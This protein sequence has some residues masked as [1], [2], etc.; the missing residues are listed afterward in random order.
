[1]KMRLTNLKNL[2]LGICA[3]ALVAS[4]SISTSIDT[5]VQAD[6][7]RVAALKEEAKVPTKI[8]NQDLIKVNDD[9]WL[10]NTS[11]I[12]YEGQPLPSYLETKD[13]ITL[14]SNRPISL[15]EIGDMINKTTSLGIRYAA[16]LEADVRAKGEMNRVGVAQETDGWVSPDTM[17]V[18]YQGPLSGFL[19]ELSS[20][21]GVWWKYENNDI[22]FYKFIT[23]TFVVYSLPTNPN[24]NVSVGG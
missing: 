7:E 8:A 12:E 20:R 22:Y 5:S 21:F 15:Y 18:S 13:G 1:M 19:D 4:C 3:V 2:T 11:L 17:L 10:G 23:K 16:D 6:I 14:V 24:M 9:I